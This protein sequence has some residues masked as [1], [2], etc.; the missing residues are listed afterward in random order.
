MGGGNNIHIYIY[1][2]RKTFVYAFVF[3]K[4]QITAKYNYKH[5]LSVKRIF[6]PCCAFKSYKIENVNYR[7][8]AIVIMKSTDHNWHDPW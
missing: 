4:L 5:Y 1:L 8:A 2:S 6:I 7:D 3:S